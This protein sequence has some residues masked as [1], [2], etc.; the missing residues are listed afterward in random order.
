M[1]DAMKKEPDGIDCTADLLSEEILL[2]ETGR[3]PRQTKRTDDQDKAGEFLKNTGKFSEDTSRRKT[4]DQRLRRV[5]VI[6]KC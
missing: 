4:R 2:T 5:T 6:E 1:D 3:H